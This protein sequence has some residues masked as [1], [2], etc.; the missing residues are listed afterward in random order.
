MS[1]QCDP[2]WRKMMKRLPNEPFDAYKR[3]RKLAQLKLK[4]Q[5]KGKLA[6]NSAVKDINGDKSYRKKK[7]TTA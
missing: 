2:N 5:M 3:R 4:E 1:L 7:T 6:W